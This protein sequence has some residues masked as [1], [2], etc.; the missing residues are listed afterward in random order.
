MSRIDLLPYQ[1]SG[2]GAGDGGSP[3]DFVAD[4]NAMMI[5]L[6]AGAGGSGSGVDGVIDAAKVIADVPTNALI[7]NY[8]PTGWNDAS[9][10]IMTPTGIGCA[11]TGAVAPNPYVA[12]SVVLKRLFNNSAFPI[13]LYHNNGSGSS[14]AGNFFQLPGGDEL[15]IPEKGSVLLGYTSIAGTA[16]WRV[17][18]MTDDRYGNVASSTGLAG[19][20]VDNWAGGTQYNHATI[21]ML[22]TPSADT[23]LSGL[24]SSNTENV[25]TYRNGRRLT[26]TN[27]SA[28]YSVTLLHQ[29]TGTTT[30]GNR[31]RCPGNQPYVLGPGASVDLLYFG[32][33]CVVARQTAL[34]V[35]DVTGG[36]TVD[37]ECRTQ[38]NA[39]LA[40]LRTAKLL[41]T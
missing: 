10:V 1:G 38:L 24:L 20:Q 41:A 39:L 26:L 33:W 31:F 7:N 21:G 15:L 37:T 40:A 28:T 19:G 30:P 4:L 22:L 18:G 34:A 23:S 25:L 35:A 16:G 3:F 32:V 14:S 13:A 27:F 29:N 11:I 17:L 12:G 6:Y 8:N 9:L 36:S 2:R 5:E